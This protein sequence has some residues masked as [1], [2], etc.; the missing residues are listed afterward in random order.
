M[1]EKK[2]KQVFEDTFRNSDIPSNL[3]GVSL[4]DIEEWDSLGNF[5]LL[6]SIEETFSIRFSME[7]MSETKSYDEIVEILK[8]K[9]I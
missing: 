8:S 7:E 4:G 5:N 2:L 9:D 6:L 3:T 1:I